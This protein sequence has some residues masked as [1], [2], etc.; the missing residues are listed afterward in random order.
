MFL[1]EEKLPYDVG[2]PLHP[3]PWVQ[4]KDIKGCL[5]FLQIL[6]IIDLQTVMR[7][8]ISFFGRETT[9]PRS[10]GLGPVGMVCDALCLGA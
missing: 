8:S 2:V 1:G 5:D 4:N 6:M 3:R 9:V 7:Y 10:S